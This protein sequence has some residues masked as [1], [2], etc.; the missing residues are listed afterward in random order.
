MTIDISLAV[1]IAAAIVALL[2]W[3]EARR[4][5]K[6]TAIALR[7]QSYEK[8]ETMPS[9]EALNVVEVGDRYR[10]KLIVFNQ[11]ETPF[12]VNCVKCFRYEPKS[13]NPLNWF[14]SKIGPFDWDY[15]CE[16][17]FW[18]PKGSLDDGEHYAEVA[19]P[20]TLVKEMEILL[21]TLAAYR[22]FPYQQYKFEIIT[23]QGTTM[24]E[25]VLPNGAT[26]LPYEHRRTIA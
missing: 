18:N 13:R 21:V 14:R 19:L 3:I 1:S 11:R 9:V 15:S 23:S 12:R 8:M 26:S 7:R 4:M 2:S 16:K 25:G 17:A 20:F 6:L 5:S 10:A 24:W 22:A